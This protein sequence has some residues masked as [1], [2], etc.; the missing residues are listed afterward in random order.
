MTLQCLRHE[1]PAAELM[2][3]NGALYQK[4]EFGNITE[5]IHVSS[6]S[7][8]SHIQPLSHNHIRFKT[9]IMNRENST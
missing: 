7:H 1:I 9:K 6:L 4:D 5:L 8:G 3:D 2:K